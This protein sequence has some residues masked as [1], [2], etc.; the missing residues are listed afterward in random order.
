[1]GFACDSNGKESACKSEKKQKESRLE[2][3]K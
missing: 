2:K 1:M 3:E